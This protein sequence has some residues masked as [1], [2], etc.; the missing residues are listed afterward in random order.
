MPLIHAYLKEGKSAEYLKGVS[1]GLH[2]ALIETWQIP[3]LDRFQ[4]WHEMKKDNLQIDKKM[5][6]VNRSEDVIV[7]H[8]FTSPRT[9]DQ[10][11]ALYERLPQILKEKGLRPEDVFVS[12][13]TNTREDWSFGNGIAHLMVQQSYGILSQAA[14]SGATPEPPKATRSFSTMS[15]ARLQMLMPSLVPLI[16]SKPFR[17]QALS[18]MPRKSFKGFRRNPALTAGMAVAAS[19]MQL[20]GPR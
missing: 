1:D 11:F 10:K 19:A 6:G 15:P 2:E 14:L 17:T 4:V 18:S 12:I 16:Q 13:S 20:F 9:P 8:I 5:W 7:F 3:E